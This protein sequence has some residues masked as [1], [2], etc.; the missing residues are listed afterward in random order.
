[1]GRIRTPPENPQTIYAAIAQVAESVS[2][3]ADVFKEIHVLVIDQG[4]ILDRIDYNIEQASDRVGLAVKELNKANE[5][6]KRSRT[7]LCIY[8]LLLLCGAMVVVLILK[9]SV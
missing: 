3:L 9:K 7:M 8:L 4:T 1:M 6:Q 5:Y 2:E